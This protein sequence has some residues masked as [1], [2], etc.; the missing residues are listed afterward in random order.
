MF[1]NRQIYMLITNKVLRK[2][3]KY[4]LCLSN[5]GITEIIFI[6]ACQKINTAMIIQMWIYF[7][8]TLLIFVFNCLCLS[9]IRIYDFSLSFTTMP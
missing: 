1:F 7:K 5:I 2:S 8:Q 4:V 9:K 6:S 3:S